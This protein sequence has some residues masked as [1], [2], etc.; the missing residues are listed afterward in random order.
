VAAGLVTALLGASSTPARPTAA[1]AVAD[2]EPE[3]PTPGQGSYAFWADDHRGGPLRWDACTPIEFV[4]NPTDAPPDAEQD[5]AAALGILAD[6]TGLELVLTD[7]TD[8]RPDRD[9]SLTVAHADGWRWRPVLV[10]WTH[11][12]TTAFL[13]EHSDRGVALPVAVRDGDREAYVTGQI[14]LNAARTDL[15]AG[16][17]DRSDAIGATLLHEIA[18]VLG[19]AHVDD[20]DELMWTEPGTGRVAFGPGD[21]AGLAKLGRQAGCNPAPPPSVGRGLIVSP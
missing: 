13:L 4:L 7:L 16:F 3:P 10:A 18:H 5:L 17:G 6:L 19:L 8:E 20:P 15:V 9:R 11:P 21:R 12:S 14:V 2:P 1:V